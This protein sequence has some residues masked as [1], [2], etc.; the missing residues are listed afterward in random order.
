LSPS[1]LRSPRPLGFAAFQTEVA[2]KPIASFKVRPSLPDPLKP[3]LPITYNLRWCW[4]HAAIDLFRRL[5]RDL[6]ETAG[7]NPVRL[8][9][10]LDQSVLE[11]AAKDDS[12]LSHLSGV[13]ER[14]DAYLS[15]KNTWYRREH[16]ADNSLL[17][18]YF[19]LEFGITECLSIFARGL[20]VLAGIISRLRATSAFLSW[21]SGCCIRRA[22]FVS[23]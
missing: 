20:G 8:L 2:M 19:S 22:T 16:A 10:S 3:L 6:W 21:V 9:G 13:S 1:S 5:D 17:V 14:L 23:T 7:H 11:N 4:D 15:S 18:A 12:F